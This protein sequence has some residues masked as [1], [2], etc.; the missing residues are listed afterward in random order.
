MVVCGRLGACH[1][2]SLC[3]RFAAQLPAIML[4]SATAGLDT[5]LLAE[6]VAKLEL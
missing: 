4:D 5:D 2:S 1:R 6:A 3:L